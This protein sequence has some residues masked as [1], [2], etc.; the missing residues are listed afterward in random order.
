MKFLRLPLMCDYVEN[1]KEIII[2][3]HRTFKYY[4]LKKNA[5]VKFIFENLNTPIS[6]EN[7][8]KNAYESHIE[9]KSIQLV[10]KKMLELGII[11]LSEIPEDVGVVDN[12]VELQYDDR[13]GL[14]IAFFERFEKDLNRF[15]IFKRIKNFKIAIIGLGGIGSNLAVMCAASGMKKI[16]LIDGDIVEKSNLIR[17]VFYKERDVNICKKV[18]SLKRFI[19]EF[20]SDIE[21]SVSEEYIRSVEDCERYIE[22]DIDL[23]IQTA[24]R[25]KGYINHIVNDYSVKYNV[26]VLYTMNRSIGPLVIPGRT[27]CFK[28]YEEDMNKES[29]GLY[30]EI[31]GNL[32]EQVGSIYPA[33]VTGPWKLA[34]F[35]FEQIIQYII[36]ADESECINHVIHFSEKFEKKIT[37]IE[38]KNACNCEEILKN[39]R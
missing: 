9:Y 19:E 16:E 18:Y 2:S 26:P 8:M 25:P 12:Y 20:N 34:P 30:K 15:E 29:N 22:K 27:I 37:A 5:V 38:R 3:N 32:S 39:E 17:Q 7:L 10:L 23:I 36:N 24:D 31:I 4:R 6:Y 14:E 13:Y 1:E 35:V 33:F 21:I 28:C 11:Y